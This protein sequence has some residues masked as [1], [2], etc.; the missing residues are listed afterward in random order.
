MIYISVFGEKSHQSCIRLHV[1]KREPRR[2]E[3]SLIASCTVS[4]S[5]PHVV[6]LRPVTRHPP[7]FP[8]RFPRLRKPSICCYG[9]LLKR[10][11]NKEEED[12]EKAAWQL[13]CCLL[14]PS[15]FEDLN[16]FDDS[17]PFFFFFL[18]LLLFLSTCK[19][20]S[21]DRPEM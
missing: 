1:F 17:F 3:S 5:E 7:L 4:L 11:S 15:D 12:W 9:I 16:I 10:K 13:I 6:G 20:T 18:F 8:P 2:C 14:F 19:N 21:L